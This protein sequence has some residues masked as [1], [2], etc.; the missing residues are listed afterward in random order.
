MYRRKSD[1][2]IVE[3]IK[4]PAWYDFIGH[5]YSYLVDGLALFEGDFFILYEEIECDSIGDAIIKLEGK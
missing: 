2:A 1:G 4:L 3:A 5:G